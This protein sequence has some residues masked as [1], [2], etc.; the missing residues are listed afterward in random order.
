[1]KR[2]LLRITIFGIMLIIMNM[3]LLLTSCT[4]IQL[5]FVIASR[6][7]TKSLN[8]LK[9]DKNNYNS[10]YLLA[11]VEG[12]F[13]SAPQD[14]KATHEVLEMTPLTIKELN[15]NKIDLKGAIQKPIN[16]VNANLNNLIK[17]STKILSKTTDFWYGVAK[18]I[19]VI[20]YG[21]NVANHRSRKF[22]EFIIKLRTT[23]AINKNLPY[24]Q[25]SFQERPSLW[26]DGK[27]VQAHDFVNS[28]KYVLDANNGSAN[29]DDLID[30][31]KVGL[32]NARQFL[33]KEVDESELG[34]KALGADLLYINLLTGFNPTAESQLANNFIKKTFSPALL[35]SRADIINK[36]GSSWGSSKETIMGNGA[37]RIHSTDFDNDTVFLKNYDYWDR[38]RITANA[39]KYKV[40]QDNVTS[41]ILFESE[42]VGKSDIPQ[43]LLPRFLNNQKLRKFL[44]QG[45]STRDS[46]YLAFNN[47][48]AKFAGESGAFLRNAIQYGINRHDF[49]LS[50]NDAGAIPA[51][52]LTTLI[53]NNDGNDLKFRETLV[54]DNGEPKYYVDLLGNGQD[55]VPLAYYRFDQRVF[56]NQVQVNIDRTDRLHKPEVAKQFYQKYLASAGRP[57]TLNLLY[58][59][60]MSANVNDAMLLLKQR[61]EKL[62]PQIKIKLV[63]QVKSVYLSNLEAGEYDLVYSVVKGKNAN[64]FDYLEI[65]SKNYQ[66]QGIT[67]YIQNPTGTWDF[68][69]EFIKDFR[70]ARELQKSNRFFQEF[71]PQAE[72][73]DIF[74]WLNALFMPYDNSNNNFAVNGLVKNQ[75]QGIDNFQDLNA[76]LIEKLGPNNGLEKIFTAA[77]GV[78]WIKSDNEQAVGG[79]AS[80]PAHIT[81][82]IYS[83][84][85]A[86]IKLKSPIIMLSNSSAGW[87]GEQIIGYSQGAL[88]NLP[89]VQWGYNCQNRN[90]NSIFAL[91]GCDAFNQQDLSR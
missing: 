22:K 25:G 30:S 9:Y 13:H 77:S 52:T 7:S 81:F 43:E 4:T 75:N 56:Y 67:R 68:Y 76:K 47:K 15:L 32:N 70:N 74:L 65:I 29:I 24:D 19:Y 54:K 61:I 37:F 55:Q 3:I 18:D 1:M 84:L 60:S 20:N 63:G 88:T 73:E 5:S 39:W 17:E 90:L 64:A 36:Y 21:T 27:V 23:D 38:D 57:Q 48:K 58:D 16:E 8:Y 87:A 2:K 53:S 91:K 14:Q 89:E 31:N 45:M 71:L 83:I 82:K 6:D 40:V 34:I 78:S 35:P 69:Q 42:I 49:L 50:K 11:V 79:L 51:D 46:E 41:S 28:V 12:L 86:I 62:L 59:L 33:H 85:E 44:F 66:E 26:H 72:F 10:Q 80:L